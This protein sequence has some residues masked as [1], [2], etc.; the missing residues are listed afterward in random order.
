MHIPSLQRRRLLTRC[1]IHIGDHHRCATFRA[2]LASR[3]TDTVPA[4][5]DENYFIVQV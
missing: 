3:L 1:L 2:E 4:A 5:G